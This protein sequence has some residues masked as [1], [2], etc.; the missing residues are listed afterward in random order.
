V[1]GIIAGGGLPEG[2]GWRKWLRWVL[3][4]ILPGRGG[5]M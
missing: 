3:R 1:N 4:V 2:S 5:R